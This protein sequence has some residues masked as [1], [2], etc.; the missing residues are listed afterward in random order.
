MWAEET[1]QKDV[2]QQVTELTKDCGADDGA[3]P[4]AER[5]HG[6]DRRLDVGRLLQEGVALLKQKRPR[7]ALPLLEGVIRALDHETNGGPIEKLERQAPRALAFNALE[8]LV[9][10]HAAEQRWRDAEQCGLRAAALL[11]PCDWEAPF[12]KTEMHKREG[13]LYL[14]LGHAADASGSDPEDHWRRAV[15]A[16]VA[17]GE[18]PSSEGQA[19]LTLGSWLAKQHTPRSGAAVGV[20]GLHSCGPHAGP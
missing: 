4:T 6:A 13:L 19:L 18:D 12:L 9:D 11:K 20:E 7:D 10:V 15:N 1:G 2:V 3:K 17:Y 14:S 8:A 16:F 5:S